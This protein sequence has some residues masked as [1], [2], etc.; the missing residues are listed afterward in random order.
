MTEP[1]NVH[2]KHK[3]P[4]D[5]PKLTRKQSTSAGVQPSLLQRRKLTR[6]HAPPR[7][8]RRRSLTTLSE[9]Q[10]CVLTE[11][12]K[13]SALREMFVTPAAPAGCRGESSWVSTETALRCFLSGSGGRDVR[14][15]YLPADTVAALNNH[16]LWFFL[17]EGKHQVNE[18]SK[19]AILLMRAVS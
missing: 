18:R 15:L 6:F 5:E 1:I 2:I 12:G 19:L 11:T 9:G 17:T 3:A 4:C 14:C 16:S 13:T 8:T 10:L 7:L